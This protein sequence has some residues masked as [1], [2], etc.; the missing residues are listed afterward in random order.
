MLAPKCPNCNTPLTKTHTRDGLAIWICPHV[1][2]NK[3]EITHGFQAQIWCVRSTP[4]AKP[5]ETEAVAVA[6]H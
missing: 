2:P 1:K 4:Q 6:Q 3:A 5:Q